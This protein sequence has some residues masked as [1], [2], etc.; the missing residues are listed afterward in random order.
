V[1]TILDILLVAMPIAALIF[2]SLRFGVE[3]RPGMGGRRRER[4][5]ERWTIR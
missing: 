3:Q 2:G 4:Y 5:G 1:T